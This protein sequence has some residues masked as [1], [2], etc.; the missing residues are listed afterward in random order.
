MLEK[1]MTMD[2]ETS[3]FDFKDRQIEVLIG[4]SDNSWSALK[5]AMNVLDLNNQTIT[6]RSLDEDKFTSKLIDSLG[7]EQ[8]SILLSESGSHSV[9]LRSR[10]PEA[11]AFKRWIAY[12]VLSPIRKTGKRNLNLKFESSDAKAVATIR[13]FKC[14]IQGDYLESKARIV[15]VV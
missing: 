12:E 3:L 11:K 10:K 2:K 6:V 4:D 5:D 8:E 15:L 9:I 13:A 7:R 14:V 1:K